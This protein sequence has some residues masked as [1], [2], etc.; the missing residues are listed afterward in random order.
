MTRLHLTLKEPKLKT[1][2]SE[3]LSEPVGNLHFYMRE[4]VIARNVNLDAYFGVATS[5][6]VAN[7]KDPPTKKRY[8]NV[9]PSNERN[10]LLIWPRCE[11]QL[12]AW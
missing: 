10:G 3:C 11:Y 6:L 8:E 12:E 7:S 5:N 2:Q 4:M 9:L 1:L